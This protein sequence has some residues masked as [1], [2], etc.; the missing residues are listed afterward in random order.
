MSKNLIIAL[1][2]IIIIFV[3]VGGL[4]FFSRTNSVVAKPSL[5]T[6]TVKSSEKSIT[7]FSFFE[8]GSKV[9]EVIDGAKHTVILVVPHGTNVTSL[10]PTISTSDFSAVS[11]DSGIVQNFTKPII[12]TVTAQDGST[13]SYT[14]TVEIATKKGFGG[15]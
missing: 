6:A 5:K 11:P 12:Y 10:T 2:V 8:L 15:S 4:W 7:S 1:I 9:G 13:Q 14:V 3:C